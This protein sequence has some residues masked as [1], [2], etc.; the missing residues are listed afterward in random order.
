MTERASIL[1]STF[2][3]AQQDGKLT[4]AGLTLGVLEI[5]SVT[6]FTVDYIAR[7]VSASLSSK[8]DGLMRYIFGFF[9]IIDLLSV[10][11]F[12]LGLSAFGGL[13]SLSAKLLPTVVS[14][15][16]GVT[17]CLHR[18]RRVSY[19]SLLSQ[20]PCVSRAP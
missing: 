10:L 18:G 19:I 20:L 3:T 13:G 15:L 5:F 2:W 1:L 11:P 16:E 14:S 8:S 6:M 9:G 7:A 12:F 4:G 17:Y